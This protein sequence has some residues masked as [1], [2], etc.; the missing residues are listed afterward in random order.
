MT[1][2]ECL[3]FDAC[4]NILEI[5]DSK[6]KDK[7]LTFTKSCDHFRNKADFVEVVRCKD[8]NQFSENIEG[9]RPIEGADG[10]CFIRM[11]HSIDTQYC[12]VCYDDYCS[13]GERKNKNG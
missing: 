4:K 7:N 5:L 11:V 3:H 8:C 2:N 13:Y 10:K 9:T 6:Y 12:G 1:C